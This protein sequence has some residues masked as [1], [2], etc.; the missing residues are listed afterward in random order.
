[1]NPVIAS[2]ENF[3]R[4]I[5][6][7]FI[8]ALLISCTGYGQEAKK[9]PHGTK[10]NVPCLTCHNETSWTDLSDLKFDHDKTGYVL[11]GGH[12]YVSCTSCHRNLIFNYVAVTCA[13]CHTDIHKGELGVECEN[14]HN[15]YNWENRQEIWEQHQQTNFPLIGAHSALDCRSCHVSEQQREFINQPVECKGCHLE[16][17]NNSVNPVHPLA[18]F[19]LDCQACHSPTAFRWQNASFIHIASFVLQ[20]GHDNLD[21]ITCH[22]KSYKETSTDCFECHRLD[23]ENALDPPHALF[24]FPTNCENC[25]TVFN[26]ERSSFDHTAESGFELVGA[27]QTTLCLSCHI[28]NQL[29]GL[30]RDCIGCHETD[31]NLAKDPDHIRNQMSTD[32][33]LCHSQ[34]AWEPATFD[35]ANTTFPLTGAHVSL[36]C[37]ECHSTGYQNTPSECWSCHEADYS[38]VEDPDHGQNN[39]D[40][41]C[42]LCHTTMNWDVSNFDHSI[43]N[44]QLTGA[45]VVLDCDACHSSGF[46]NTPIECVACHQQDYDN[47]SDPNHAAAFFPLSCENCHTSTGWTPVNWDHDNQYFPIYSGSHREEWDSCSDC[48]VDLNDYARFECINCHEHRKSKMDEEHDEE[49]DYEYNSQVCLSCHPTGTH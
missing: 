15:F 26:W 12:K 28:N 29:T 23:Y 45:H 41:N 37:I 25:H 16:A 14:C 42:M 39:F 22:E 6:K 43:T 19:S 27:H 7:I 33:N 38:S 3:M 18:G 47:T 20:G 5:N 10:F 2:K 21:C 4:T 49:S 8:F 11:A 31:Y 32:C 44:F 1:V 46:S 30:P 24:G 48:H 9:N 17:Y 34:N 40:H 35:H 36:N 13:D